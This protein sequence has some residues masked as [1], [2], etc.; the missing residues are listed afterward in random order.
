M[1]SK[2][3]GKLW[4]AALLAIAGISANSGYTGASGYAVAASPT[5]RIDT[6]A[7]QAVLPMAE[8]QARDSFERFLE[9]ATLRNRTGPDSAV[10]IRQS[11]ADL[12]LFGVTRT[13]EGFAGHPAGLTR[14]VAFTKND[15]VDWSHAARDGRMHGNFAARAMMDA[16][17]D[18]RAAMIATTLSFDP[19][20]KGW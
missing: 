19:L 3:R 5:D 18:Y 7:L 2:R 8:M 16:L 11:G 14:P 15:V 9:G 17:P 6:A 12:W 20:P 13:K 1:T 10:R 4:A